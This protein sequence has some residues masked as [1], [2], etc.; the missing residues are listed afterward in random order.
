[1]D[2]GRFYF[3]IEEDFVLREPQP[4][5]LLAGSVFEFY[6]P[7]NGQ[8]FHV[9][10]EQDPDHPGE[11]QPHI[12]VEG[13]GGEMGTYSTGY[14]TTLSEDDDDLFRSIDCQESVD[15]IPS[16]FLR[17][18]PSGV[19]DQHEI[20][21]ND[22]IEYLITF[23]NR[24]GRSIEHGV[25]FDEI[26]PM[27]DITSL[28]LGSS[29]HPYRATIIQDNVLKFEF[30]ELNI[31]SERAY[32]ESAG[33]IK[34]RMNL[35][36]GLPFGTVIENQ[37]ES[38]FNFD[39]TIISNEV[40]NTIG[41]QLYFT[42]VLSENLNTNSSFDVL[43]YPNPAIEHVS[44]ELLGVQTMNGVINIFDLHG[45]RVKE[46][47]FENSNARQVDLIGLQKGVYVLQAINDE[48]RVLGTA[49]LVVQ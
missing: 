24:T 46:I 19:G 27:L 25:I 29:S 43:I 10:A 44:F 40:F 21:A 35:K 42:M 23:E 45:K 1:M 47:P 39:T 2:E 11:S 5:E 37:I 49:K 26:S 34:F 6:E 9:I 30:E 41:D 32:F 33:F 20:L 38:T 22:E 13:C 12:V 17:V 14:V 28:Q 48:G 18:F 4:F 3:I 8:T 7:A 16:M 31:P 36:E 15:S